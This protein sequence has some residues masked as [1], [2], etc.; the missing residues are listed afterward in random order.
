V[1][2]RLLQEPS[3]QQS[4]W[5]DAK[6]LYPRPRRS[7]VGCV[8]V[9]LVVFVVLATVVNVGVWWLTAGHATPLSPVSAGHPSSVAFQQFARM[10]QPWKATGPYEL[11]SI[12]LTNSSQQQTWAGFVTLVGSNGEQCAN[13]PY[14]SSTWRVQLAPHA[15]VEVPCAIVATPGVLV[16]AE[17]FSGYWPAS[18]DSP[19]TPL[20]QIKSVG[21]FQVEP[22]TAPVQAQ[23]WLLIG[24]AG[25]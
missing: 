10:P 6:G 22:V 3:I 15:S 23:P 4:S 21:P 5:H 14:Q 2:P 19:H 8:A 24:I 16:S 17:A 11:G 13:S 12:W 18:V 9:L 20:L 7:R 1:Q 25:N